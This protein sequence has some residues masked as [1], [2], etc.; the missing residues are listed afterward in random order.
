MKTI[1]K[2]K[3]RFI[4]IIQTLLIFIGILILLLLMKKYGVH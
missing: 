2:A 3:E 1:K 4:N